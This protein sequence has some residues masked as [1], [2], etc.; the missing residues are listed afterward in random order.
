MQLHNKLHNWF[1]YKFKTK[2][3]KCSIADVIFTQF[4]SHLI[5]KYVALKLHKESQLALTTNF[6]CM[7]NVHQMKSVI[8]S[9]RYNQFYI[10]PKYLNFGR[11]DLLK[12]R[13]PEFCQ[14][15]LFLLQKDNQYFRQ[16]FFFLSWLPRCSIYLNFFFLLIDHVI[17]I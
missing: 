12:T 3:V 7:R 17:Q 10:R 1:A 14:R 6:Q 9:F 15:F 8:K 5:F 4:I 16:Q 2:L 11:A 13:Q